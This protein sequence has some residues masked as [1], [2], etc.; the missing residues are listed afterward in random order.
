[1]DDT[2]AMDET[3]MSETQSMAGDAVEEQPAA[4]TTA[5]M[6]AAPLRSLIIE[7]EIVVPV[8]TVAITALPMENTVEIDEMFEDVGDTEQFK[9]MDLAR[10]SPNLTTFVKLIEQANLVQDIERLNEATLF[11]PTNEAFAKMDKQKLEML[12]MPD[13]Q[14]QLMQLIQAHVLPSKVSSL[15]FNT[16]QRIELTEDSYLPVDVT[17][18]G[19]NVVVGGATIVKNNIEAS[20]GFIHV[21]DTVIQPDE[22]AVED[23]VGN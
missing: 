4:A 2:T 18:G 17:L 1:M 10:K 23:A 5:P 12:L 3:T 9:V 8:A 14:A 13:N 16:T 15:Q 21:V 19:T 11:A 7:R 20:N 6:D 22:V